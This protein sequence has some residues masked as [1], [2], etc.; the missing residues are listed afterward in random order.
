[1]TNVTS[2]LL[3]SLTLLAQT[4]SSLAFTIVAVGGH[5]TVLPRNHALPAQSHAAL[6]EP[7]RGHVAITLPFL[8]LRCSPS[9]IASCSFTLL[10]TASISN[11]TVLTTRRERSG[12]ATG[13]LRAALR[14]AVCAPDQGGRSNRL[15]LIHALVSELGSANC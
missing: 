15:R 9:L 10:L 6:C 14:A 13:V 11:A 5:Q 3:P 12:G 8:I 1:M 2:G 7:H 4:F